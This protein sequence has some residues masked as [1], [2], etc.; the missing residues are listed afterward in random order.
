MICHIP[1]S[2]IQDFP[3]PKIHFV[4]PKRLH[5]TDLAFFRRRAFFGKILLKQK[6]PNEPNK[7][8]VGWVVSRLYTTHSKDIPPIRHCFHICVRNIYIY[9]F[10]YMCVSVCYVYPCKRTPRQKLHTYKLKCNKYEQ[11]DTTRTKIFFSYPN[12]L[13]Q[14]CE[15]Y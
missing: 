8:K 15:V 9:I 5:H 4:C 14:S 11:I 6:Y 10:I 3:K 1:A 12:T 13:L 2:C 7:D